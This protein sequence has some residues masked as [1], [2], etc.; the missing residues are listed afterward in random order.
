MT[1]LHHL[2]ELP[3]FDGRED[4]TLR[5]MR[6]QELVPCLQEGFAKSCLQTKAV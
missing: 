4:N 2:S 6:V 5:H 1:G 3:E